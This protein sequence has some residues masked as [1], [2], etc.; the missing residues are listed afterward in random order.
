MSEP[1]PHPAHF[2]SD[3]PFVV[4]VRGVCERYPEVAEVMAHGRVTW[5]AGNRQFAIAGAAH[6]PEQAV[7]VRVDPD[8][9]EALL[10]RE[11][12]W[13]PAYDGAWGYLAIAA[14]ASAD[15]DWIGEL[16]DASYRS[17]ANGRQRRALDAD[18]VI[19]LGG[20]E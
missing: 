9:R 14:G 4:R 12:V 1:Q 11:D 16:I 15:W 5:R 8:E 6:Q 20:D 10:E 13:V 18:P 7:V 2:S 17:V 3:H 19:R